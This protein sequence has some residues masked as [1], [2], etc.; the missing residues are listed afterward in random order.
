MSNQRRDNLARMVEGRWSIGVTGTHGRATVSSMVAWILE[1]A[2]LHPGFAITA[3]AENFGRKSSK[4]K[5][6]WMVAEL[7]ERAAEHHRIHCDYVVCSFLEVDP[8]D[9]YQG[10][11]DIVD[12]MS[13]FL[14]SNRSLKEAFVNLDCQG[15]RQ[16]VRRAPLRPTGYAMQHRAEF[17]GE[18]GKTSDQNVEFSAYHRDQKIGDFQLGIPG[19]YNAVNAL[20]AIA[21]TYRMGIAIEVVADALESYAGMENRN[22]VSRGGGVVFIKDFDRHP[23]GVQRVIDMARGLADGRMIIAFEPDSKMLSASFRRRYEAAFAGSDE[24]FVTEF[25]GES[26]GDEAVGSVEALVE[27]FEARGLQTT[28]ISAVET[29]DEAIVST[30]GKGDKI[31][32]LG[33]DRLLR[34]ADHIQAELA[35]RAAQTP[36]EGDQPRFDGPLADTG[37]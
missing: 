4:G 11:G 23:A 29:L 10:M 19:A 6:R 20:G 2:G 35:S 16:L 33:G 18:L 37:E 22:I 14:E 8:R 12:A 13:R 27:G 25:P 34:R 9:Y 30:A 21:V 26:P 5:G 32:F 15:N 7:D 3:R 17:R 36:A 24:V 28:T 1:C 31:V